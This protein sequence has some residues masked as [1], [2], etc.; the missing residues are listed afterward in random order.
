MLNDV[1]KL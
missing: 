1:W